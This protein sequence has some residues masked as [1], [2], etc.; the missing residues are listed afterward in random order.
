MFQR[1][2]YTSCASEGVGLRDVY[3]IIR[4][5]HNRNEKSGLTGCLLF[6]DGYFIQLL[7][8]GPYAVEQRY[9][10]ILTDHRHSQIEKRLDINTNSLLFADEWMALR[11]RSMVDPELLRNTVYSPGFPPERFNGEQI[12]DFLV[13]CFAAS[14]I[15]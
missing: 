2:I 11:D 14:Q 7:E 4:M 6:L 9:A 5:S 3:D 10:R 13:N 8:G 1:I 12:L 15:V